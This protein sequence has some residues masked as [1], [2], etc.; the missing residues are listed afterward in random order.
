MKRKILMVLMPILA[1]G[2]IGCRGWKDAT[3]EEKAE[4]AAEFV[5]YKL[6]LDESQ[7]VTLNR[8]KAELLAE[9]KE[10]KPNRLAIVQEAKAQAGADQFDT[11]N[12]LRMRAEEHQKRGRVMELMIVK[13]AE[14][15]AVLRPEQKQ[16]LVKLIEKAE[17]RMN[18]NK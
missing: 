12:L 4:W 13:A 7:M 18:R 9:Y 16:K 5:E 2:F 10:L 8:I 15:H 14:L 11:S 6:D 3:P 17:K 1:V